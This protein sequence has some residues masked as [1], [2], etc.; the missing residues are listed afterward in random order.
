MPRLKLD[1]GVTLDYLDLGPR[2]GTPLILLHGWIDSWRIWEA[3][4][5][6]FPAFYRL[7]LPSQR[8]FGD[9]DKP[10]DDYAMSTYVRDLEAFAVALALERFAL[11]GHSMGGFIAHH[12]AIEHPDRLTHLVLVGTGT[13]GQTN[14]ILTAETEGLSALRDPLDPG[15]I[16][17]AQ[18]AQQRTPVPEGRLDCLIYESSKAP[19]HVLAQTWAA[20]VAENHADRLGE[21]RIPTLIL[22]GGDDMYFP[23]HEEEALAAAIPGSTLRLYPD[24]GHGV[25]W[26]KPEQFV[27]DVTAFIGA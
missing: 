25:Q 9:S 1:T 3:A 8:G 19:A 21:I 26:E 27:H 6:Y 4:L 11:I 7:I 17:E 13:T 10:A 14:P 2:D 22:C 24:V 18:T 15:F 23:V 16:R 5:P 12:Y 20:F